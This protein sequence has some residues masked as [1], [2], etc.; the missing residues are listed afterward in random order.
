M[1]ITFNSAF[2]ASRCYANGVLNNYGTYLYCNINYQS[3]TLSTYRIDYKIASSETWNNIATT[4][5]EYWYDTVFVSASAILSA[6]YAYDVRIT[7]TNDNETVVQSAFVSTSFVLMDFNS[8]GKGMAIGKVSEKPNAFEFGTDVYDRY[9]TLISN[10]LAFYQEGGSTNPNTTTEELILTSTNTPNGRLYF[11]R[12]MFYA[13]KS[14]TSNRS[15]YAYPYNSNGSTY[16]RTYN[17]SWSSWVEQPMII[18][19]GQ[20]GIWT[21]RKY[22][23]G[24]SECFGKIVVSGIAVSSALGTWYRSANLY[25]ETEYAYP[26]S[27]SENPCVDLMFQTTNGNGAFVWAFSSSSSNALYYL[28]QSYL[29]RPVTATSVTGNINI[30]VKG[31][32]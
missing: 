1:A 25:S 32:S 13:S 10:G 11:V 2:K 17:G 20:S 3:D 31:L 7:V 28:P 29:I 24:T 30:I 21:Y 27:F 23:D 19:S 12:T 22:S 8:S 16:F 18:Q 9:N 5:G 14:S 4:G 6:D 15:Q 26:I